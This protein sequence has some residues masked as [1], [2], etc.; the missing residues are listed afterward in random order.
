VFADKKSAE[1]AQQQETLQKMI[2][3]KLHSI[4]V[5]LK[6]PKKQICFESQ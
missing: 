1:D 3:Q 5:D 4:A 2:L 6:N